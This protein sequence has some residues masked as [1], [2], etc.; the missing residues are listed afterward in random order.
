MAEKHPYL[1]TERAGPWVA[2]MRVRDADVRDG[3]KA[4]WLTDSQAEHEVRNGTITK[5]VTSPP[6]GPK[7]RG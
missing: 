1:L 2:G 6:K 5:M 4:V 7:K 3:K